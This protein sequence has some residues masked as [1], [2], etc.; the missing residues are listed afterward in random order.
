MQKLLISLFISLLFLSC[1]TDN[2]YNQKTSGELNQTQKSNELQNSISI[3]TRFL[4]EAWRNKDFR[5]VK[6]LVTSYFF[7]EWNDEQKEIFNLLYHEYTLVQ[8]IYVKLIN[9]SDKTC[10][11]HFKNNLRQRIGQLPV[12]LPA[13][14]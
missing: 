7:D 14:P 11:I 6:N 5:L 10:F 2:P 1:S 8:T 12:F 9:K 4:E 13:F 3:I